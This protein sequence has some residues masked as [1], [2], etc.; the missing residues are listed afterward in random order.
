MEERPRPPSLGIL[1]LSTHEN[2]LNDLCTIASEPFDVTVFTSAELRERVES[3]LDADVEWVVRGESE[4]LSSFLNSVER[5]SSAL[6]ALYLM[7]LSGTMLDFVRYARFRADCPTLLTVFNA[8]AWLAPNLRFTPKLY[9]YLRLPLRRLIL[10][11]VDA[12]VVEYD[13][14]AKFASERTSLPVRVMTPVVADEPVRPECDDDCIQ[15]TIPGMIDPER[16]DYST[17]VDAIERLSDEYADRLRLRLLGRPVG[18][19]GRAVVESFDRLREAGW[20]I[21]HHE[22]WIPTDA[23]RAGLRDSDLLLAPLHPT[24]NYGVSVEEYGRTKTSGAIHD[25]VRYGRPLLLAGSYEPPEPLRASVRDYQ[26][27]AGL[28]EELERLFAGES[29]LADLQAAAAEASRHYGLGRQR[30]RL[31][32]LFKEICSS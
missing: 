22:E 15:V 25:S 7:P 23:F 17:V 13:T 6:D 24:K 20:T 9:N 1:E 27:A 2:D 11:H 28:A 29:A 8:N 21:D 19:R 16:R 32:A 14:I 18:E 4:S 10:Q 5:R 26:G 3:S 12:V 31:V 30:E